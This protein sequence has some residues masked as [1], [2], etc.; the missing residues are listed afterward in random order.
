[1]S[2]TITGG[3]TLS[4]GGWTITAAPPSSATAGWFGGGT[5]PSYVSTV[6]RITYATDTATSV[7]KGPLSLVRANLSAAS[8]LQ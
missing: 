5:T 1:M 8:G 7:N 4:S 3:I 2:L 6:Q